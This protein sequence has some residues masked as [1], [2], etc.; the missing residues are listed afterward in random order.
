MTRRIREF[1]LI[2]KLILVIFSFHEKVFAEEVIENI[3]VKELIK[4]RD[5]FKMPDF[6]TSE[7]IVHSESILEKYA[8][9]KFKVI[10][11]T[12]GPK[13]A[14]ALIKAPSGENYFIQMNTKIG[15]RK[16][17]VSLISANE[18][19]ITESIPSIFGQEEKLNITL[20][21]ID[22]KSQTQFKLDQELDDSK[23]NQDLTQSQVLNPNEKITNI[24][25]KKT[26]SSLLKNDLN[27][28][29]QPEP[30]QLGERHV[31]NK[32]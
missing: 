16:G 1:L 26:Q 7:N 15:L 27:A 30:H 12:T 4:L 3:N 24:L 28:V 11:I 14:K 20:N 13:E 31:D 2:L 6:L 17:I 29:Q 19:V 22:S 21:L 8:S 18:I 5:P 9:D 32:F 23:K 10:A 25:E